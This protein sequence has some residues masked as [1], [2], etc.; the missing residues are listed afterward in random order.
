M[1][2]ILKNRSFLV[3]ALGLTLGACSGGGGG[4]GNGGGFAPPPAGT[5]VTVSGTV[6]YEYVPANAGCSGLNFAGTEVRPIRGAT[7]VLLNNTGGELARTTSTETGGYSFA[8]VD[9]NAI[10]QIRVLAESKVAA[11]AS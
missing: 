9:T 10:V 5:P 1:P 3:A 2:G 11:T 7:V 6:R 4:D 8:N